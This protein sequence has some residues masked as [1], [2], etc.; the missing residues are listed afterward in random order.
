MKQSNVASQIKGDTVIANVG[1]RE[2]TPPPSGN[3]FQ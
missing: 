3:S 1:E 2:E